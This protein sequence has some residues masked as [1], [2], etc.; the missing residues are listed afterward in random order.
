MVLNLGAMSRRYPAPSMSRYPP[1]VV[2]L[3]YPLMAARRS[4]FQERSKVFSKSGL[5]RRDVGSV[6][7]LE[8]DHALKVRGHLRA[9]LNHNQRLASSFGAGEEAS[10]VDN[11]VTGCALL[12][13]RGLELV[14]RHE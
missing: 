13:G 12:S 11:V 5:D 4:A 2:P 8:V 10:L 3:A 9:F 14:V 6:L 7:Q 1:V